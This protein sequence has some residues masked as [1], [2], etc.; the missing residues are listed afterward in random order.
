MKNLCFHEADDA[1][2]LEGLEMSAES[3]IQKPAKIPNGLSNGYFI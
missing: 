1:W 3:P 2:G